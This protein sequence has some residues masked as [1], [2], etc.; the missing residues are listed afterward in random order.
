MGSTQFWITMHKSK[1]NIL[2]LYTLILV[3]V[4][5]LLPVSL[6]AQTS[7]VNAYSPYSMYGLGEI[8][9]PGSVQMRSMGGV[10]IGLRHIGQVNT[11]NPAAASV[12]PQKSFLFDVN[13][14]ATHYRNRQPKFGAD[15][16]AANDART[17]YNTANIHNIGFALPL[18]KNLGLNFNITPYSSVGYKIKT[19]DQQQDNWADIGRVQYV[20]AGEGDISEVKLAIGWAPVRNLS[21]GVAAKYFWGSIDRQYT[22]QFPDV[23]TGSGEYAATVGTD[24]YTVNNFKFQAGLQWNII[25]SDKQM[26]TLGATYDLGGRLNPNKQSYLYTNNAYHGVADEGF[27]IRRQLDELDLRM[28]HKFGVG[29]FYASR[30]LSCGVDYNYDMWGDDNT[31]YGENANDKNV[32]VAYKNTQNVKLGFEYTPRRTDTRSYFNR[33]SYR[34]GARIG[35]YYQTFG[36][37]PINTLAITAG[38]GLPLR[39][40]GTSSVN[41][42][43]EYG[44]MSSPKTIVVNAQKVGLT[45]QNY[46]KLSVGFSLFSIDTSDYWFV[47]QKFD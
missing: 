16:A 28:P 25:Y 31:G 22:T 43:F 44:R 35:N 26:L 2:R 12:T 37:E 13:F 14:D 29:I 11:L 30:T 32:V 5:A 8:L 19:T 45:T 20:Y 47:R 10:G 33:V 24:T 23:V 46:F 15:G 38:L 9:T 6:S 21:I 40:W 39:L 7:S 18:A 4:A 27:P 1:N 34:V 42:A 36:G 41:V 17:V 3:A